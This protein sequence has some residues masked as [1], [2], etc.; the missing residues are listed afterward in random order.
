MLHGVN[1]LYCDNDWDLVVP[2]IYT[3]NQWVPVTATGYTN[4]SWR[5]F[6]DAGTL[7]VK[8]ITSDGQEFYTS[9]GELF[10][11]RED[12]VLTNVTLLTGPTKTSYKVGEFFDPTGLSFQATYNFHGRTY[13]QIIY[14]CDYEHRYL[15]TSD[16]TFNVSIGDYNIIINLTIEAISILKSLQLFK[17][18]NKISYLVGEQFDPTGMEIS[19]IISDGLEDIVNP[20]A[21]NALSY[22]HNAL[23]EL[24][25]EIIIS[26]TYG[27]QSYSLSIPIEVVAIP[28]V[29]LISA[30]QGTPSVSY[31]YTIQQ[32]NTY[33]LALIMV[34]D[35]GGSISTTNC[36]ELT[37]IDLLP[38]K[39]NRKVYA[40]LIQGNSGGTITLTSNN[41]SGTTNCRTEYCLC[42][43]SHKITIQ[44]TFFT[45]QKEDTSFNYSSTLTGNR[46]RYLVLHAQCGNTSTFTT[47]GTIS[48]T[49]NQ[50]YNLSIYKNN[51]DGLN[52][53]CGVIEAINNISI[54][55]AG[56]VTTAGG[57]NTVILTF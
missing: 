42:Q 48:G 5:T 12:P 52:I 14:S 49:L 54:S 21:L 32:S 16:T 15:R 27:T 41:K 47:N 22:S 44:N 33:Y 50:D 31:T 53:V 46:Q 56:N 18:P 25:T 4:N 2:Y 7:M 1:A 28:T 10:L 26:Y 23:N 17:M 8:F 9:D 45:Q 30:A 20:I 38:S 19:S 13:T 55:F 6:G 11:V 40:K 29:T 24:D 51:T 34:G 39:V 37:T 43:L 57:V 36:I 35:S 3:N